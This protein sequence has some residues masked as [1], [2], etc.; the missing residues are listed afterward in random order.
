MEDKPELCQLVFAGIPFRVVS[1][2]CISSVYAGVCVCVCALQFNLIFN[3]NL[4]FSVSMWNFYKEV[5]KTL[6]FCLLFL[7]QQ[8]PALE[9]GKRKKNKN[10]VSMLLVTVLEQKMYA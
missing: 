10:T 1:L 3:P 8:T 9:E 7:Q 5:M 6:L 2:S 4:F